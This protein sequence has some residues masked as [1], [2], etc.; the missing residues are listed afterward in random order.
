MNS[1]AIAAKIIAKVTSQQQSL[2]TALASEI[3]RTTQ[4]ASFI[5]ELCF[6]VLRWYP[7]LL[8]ILQT[9]QHV[10]QS[11]WESRLMVIFIMMM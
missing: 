8:R 7:K 3:N 10:R 9:S 11:Y 6:G 5:Q 2:T 4:D 1:R